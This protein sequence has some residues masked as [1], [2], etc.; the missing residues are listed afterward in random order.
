MPSDGAPLNLGG[1]LIG[2]K[3]IENHSSVRP[4]GGRGHVIE[5]TG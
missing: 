4:R 5:V 2:V 1:L 3:T